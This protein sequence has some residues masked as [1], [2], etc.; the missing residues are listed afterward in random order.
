MEMINAI[1]RRKASVARVYLKK[2]EGKIVVNGKDY[3]EYFPQNHIQYNLTDPFQTVEVENIYD[4]KINVNGGGYKG[5]AEAI[6]MGI[7][8]ALVKLNEDFRKPLKDKK[9]LTRDSR[10]VERKKYGKPKARKSFQFSK[11]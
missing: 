4:L 7:A 8:R 3:K 11:R 9:Y 5:Q 10:V 2:G 6:R 1:G